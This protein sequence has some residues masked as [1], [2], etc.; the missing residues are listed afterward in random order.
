MKGLKKVLSG[1]LCAAMIGTG[2]GAFAA[3]GDAPETV[4]V[5]GSSSVTPLMEKLA[6]QYEKT[7]DDVRISVNMSDSGTGISDALNGL[8]DIGMA[9]RNLKN[10][11]SGVEGKVLC[12]D[13]IAL[14]V[15]S[16]NAVED[17][18]KAD[19]KALYESLTPIS[20]TTITA[21]VG[22]TEGSGTRSAFDDLMKI[23]NYHEDLSCVQETGNVI[24]TIKKSA[25][26]LGYISFGSL[27]SAQ[28]VKAVKVGGV[29]C[30]YDNIVSGSYE[31][32]RPFV[33]VT[34]TG[35]KLSKAAQGFYD[36]I[37]STD[38]QSVITKAGY[39]SVK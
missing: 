3:C 17:V 26:S 22:R 23:E 34:K 8:N 12:M 14:I 36:Y 10:T 29:V 20:G 21:G 4:K 19:V 24:E 16:D 32:Q 38:A 15:K 9:S 37:M 7:H 25:N 27:A 30:S 28:G 6:A 18:T 31:L 33:I 35:K 1:V 5:S 11:E 39:I 13:G 2:M